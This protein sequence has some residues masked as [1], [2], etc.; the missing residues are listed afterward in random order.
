M[1]ETV[2]FIDS[3]CKKCGKRIGW[4]G[5]V[6]D[7]PCCPR[8]GAKPDAAALEHDQ[9]EVDSFRELLREMKERVPGWSQWR[10]ARVAAGL[11][12]RQAARILDVTPTLLSLIEQA[13]A[14]PLPSLVGRM[15]ACYSGEKMERT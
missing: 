13:E 9:A 1:T 8:C 15:G 10:R 7:M 11:T 3:V 4:H 6:V 14:S 2:G 12:L 5:R